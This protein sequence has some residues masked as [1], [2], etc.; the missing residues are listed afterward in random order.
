M[1]T[2]GSI[3]AYMCA[4]RLHWTPLPDSSAVTSPLFDYYDPTP[5]ADPDNFKILRNDWPY[6]SSEPNISH[7]IVWS[8]SRIPTD[9]DSGLPTLE[10]RQLI[11]AFVE[12]TFVKRLEMEGPHA[13]ERVGDIPEDIIREW[14]GEKEGHL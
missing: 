11:E 14:T 9:A 7:L 4:E 6:G 2:Y 5:F 12:Q 8:K 13:R 10:S 1:T 3:T